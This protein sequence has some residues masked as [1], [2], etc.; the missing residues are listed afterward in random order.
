MVNARGS[1]D[2]SLPGYGPAVTN[3]PLGFWFEEVAVAAWRRAVKSVM[4]YR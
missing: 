3:S 1:S 2:P 4:E